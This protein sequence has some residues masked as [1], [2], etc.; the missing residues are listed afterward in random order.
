[1]SERCAVCG[2]PLGGSYG[3]EPGNYSM[4]PLSTP[5]EPERAIREYGQLAP[6]SWKHIKPPER[7]YTEPE[8]QATVAAMLAHAYP[9]MC[10]HCAAGKPVKQSSDGIWVHYFEWPEG[11]TRVCYA[12]KLRALIPA[13]TLAEHDAAITLVKEQNVAK[14]IKTSA[15][16][17]CMCGPCSAAREAAALA[18]AE[19]RLHEADELKQALRRVKSQREYVEWSDKRIS[20]LQ[21]AVDVAKG[22]GAK[23]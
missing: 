10:W 9:I 23:G 19:A 21:D 12:H 11:S 2:W 6:E 13:Q 20:K 16:D 4:R 8:H 18:V 5:I 15:F 3:C 14:H 1:M 7:T 17:G 22:G